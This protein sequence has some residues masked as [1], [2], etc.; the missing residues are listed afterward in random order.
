MAWEYDAADGFHNGDPGKV[1]RTAPAVD[2]QGER[3]AHTGVV[4]GLHEMVGSDEENA[5]P[6]AR[7]ERDLP[8]QGVDQIVTNFGREAPE[9]DQRL[10]AA[11]GFHAGRLL[12]GE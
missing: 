12:L 10:P 6:V 2:G 11:D 4:E 7:L 9:L 8:S 5:I 3:P 1:L